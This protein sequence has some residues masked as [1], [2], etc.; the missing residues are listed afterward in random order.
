VRLALVDELQAKVAG[1]DGDGGRLALGDKSDAQSAQ[2]RDVDAEA[3]VRGEAFEF[4]AMQL[5]V[6]PGWPPSLGR[7]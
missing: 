6:G 5:A 4:Q 2:A 1:A 7:K 3:I